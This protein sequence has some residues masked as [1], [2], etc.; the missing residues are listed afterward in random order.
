MC[1]LGPKWLSPR[2]CG[3]E[4][5]NKCQVSRKVIGRKQMLLMTHLIKHNSNPREF[6]ARDS[7]WFI[8]ALPQL[9]SMPP[10]QCS[11]WVQS[12][13]LAFYG[14]DGDEDKWW[15][16]RPSMRGV[17]VSFVPEGHQLTVLKRALQSRFSTPLPVVLLSRAPE[18][19]WLKI[20]LPKHEDIKNWLWDMFTK[21]N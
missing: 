14:D 7:N 6:L 3:I 10:G 1:T 20:N 21:L 19:F 11:A 12:G 4:R 13:N 18:I 17:S 9:L 15:G 16:R 2:Q 8:C 5:L